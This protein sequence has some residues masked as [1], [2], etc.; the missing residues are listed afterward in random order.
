[1]LFGL[2]ADVHAEVHGRAIEMKAERRFNERTRCAA[3]GP[4]QNALSSTVTAYSCWPYD[5]GAPLLVATRVYL[6]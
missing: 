3:N 5:E 1:M 2:R 4:A 6:M